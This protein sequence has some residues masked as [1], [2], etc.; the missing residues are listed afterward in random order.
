MLNKA[1]IVLSIA[2]ISIV[3]ALEYDS[4]YTQ[5]TQPD[6][7]TFT[8][9][10][11]SDEFSWYMETQAGYRFILGGNGY[12][13]YASLDSIGEYKSSNVKVAI[14]PP[15]ASSFYLE[16]SPVRL[17]EIET[18]KTEFFEEMYLKSQLYHQEHLYNTRE[19]RNL[20][21]ILV[22]FSDLEHEGSDVIPKWK[23]DQR[24]F[25]DGEWYDPEGDD[26]IHPNYDPIFGSVRDY[27][28]EQTNAN[29]NIL[30]KDGLPEVLNPR[31]NPSDPDSPPVW[32]NLGSVDSYDNGSAIAVAKQAAIDAGYM[33]AGEYLNIGV[34]FAGRPVNGLG[35][36]CIANDFIISNQL[37]Q[38]F[39]HIGVIAHEL[40]HAAFGFFEFHGGTWSL[41]DGG[42]YNG[43]SNHGECPS[44]LTPYEKIYNNWI[45]PTVI[46]YNSGYTNPIDLLYN[47]NDPN[48]LKINVPGEL[49]HYFLLEN[50]LRDG[51]DEYTPNSPYDTSC[52][53]DLSDPNGNLGGLLI[54]KINT[55]TIG[56]EG[57]DHY[58]NLILS[59]EGDESCVDFR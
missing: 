42:S 12:Y 39:T 2:Y 11:W 32:L 4:G 29:V 41:M 47:Y 56:Y 26:D 30:G 18:E 45:I 8:G 48:Y 55:T 15:L 38:V 33:F 54:W 3:L 36:Q 21:I 50:R 49:H 7:T 53:L 51:W 57:Y 24:I 25:S 43:P 23:Y 20:G 44:G 19:D 5:Y 40:G 9:R 1:Q 28:W 31:Q 52:D 35:N 14:D 34:I 22:E 46:T 16:R 13:Y 27:Y 58:V 6:G 59:N 17:Q 37:F 10:Y